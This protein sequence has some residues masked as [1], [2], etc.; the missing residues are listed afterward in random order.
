MLEMDGHTVAAVGSGEAAQDYL[1]EGHTS[2]DL[3]VTDVVMPG[4]SGIELVERLRAAGVTTP[5]LLISG[6]LDE[7]QH[8]EIPGDPTTILLHKPFR[9]VE[10]QEHVA[11]LTQNGKEAVA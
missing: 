7:R 3:L 9:R 5:A 2:V 4:I 8:G 6:F 11:L 1:E 10:L